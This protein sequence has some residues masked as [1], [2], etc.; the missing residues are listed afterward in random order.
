MFYYVGVGYNNA[1]GEKGYMCKCIA[2]NK[3]FQVSRGLVNI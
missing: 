3:V 2:L 1:I